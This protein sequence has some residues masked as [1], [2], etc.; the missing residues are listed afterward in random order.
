MRFTRL[1]ILRYGALTDRALA[2]R[3]DAQLH[4]IYGPNE[5]GKS[6]ALSAISD[7]LFGFPTAAEYSFLHDATALRVGAEIETRDGSKLGFR[8]RRG[9][10]NTL[11]A[12]SEAEEALPED[13][14]APFL[15]TLNRDVFQ[16]AFGLDSASLR[17]GGQSMLKSGGEIGSLLFSAASGLTGLSDLRKSFDAEAD[18]I[19]APRRSKDR[20]FY[21]VLDSHDEARKAERDNELKSGD[22]KKLLAEQAELEAELDTV[23]TERE[24]TK[25]TLERLR[26]LMRLEPVLREID[27]EQNQLAQYQALASL[28]PGFEDALA[29]ALDEARRNDDAHRAAET[30]VTRLRD[31]IA[32]LHVDDALIAAAGSILARHADKGVYLK[33]REDI[34]RV[35]GEVEDF[36]TRLVQL[37]RRLGLVR[38]DDLERHQP[39]DADLVRL[40]TLLDEGSE[41]DRSLKQL[42]LRLE[43]EREALRRL[44]EANPDSRLIDPKPWAEQLTALRPEL[45]D[46]AGIENLQVRATR[47][48]SDLAAAVARLDPPVKDIDALLASPLPDLAALSSHRKLID[49]ARAVHARINQTL[50]TVKAEAKTV[51]DQVAALEGQGR[52]VSRA[53]ILEAR[54]H[55]DAGLA[56]LGAKPSADQLGDVQKAVQ[57][58]DELA[59]AALTDAERV[60]RHAQLSLRQHEI[61]QQL[62]N[63]RAEARESDIALSDA[64]TEFEDL[65]RSV[66]ISPL[67]PERMLEWRRGVEALSHQVDALKDAN[68]A[69]QTARLKEDRLKPVLVG[70][71]D[72]IG[73]AATALPPAALARAL[74]RRLA[75]IAERWTESRSLEG[76]RHSAVD[77]L[78]RL[79]ERET[80]LRRE[81]DSWRASFSNAATMAGLQDEATVEMAAAALDVWR[82]VPDLLAERENR[83]RRVRGMQRDM[84]TFDEEIRSLCTKVAPD[85]ISVPADVAAGLLNDRAMDANAA[86]KHKAAM[87][88]DLERA[89][90]AFERYA[91]RE[92]TLQDELASLATS[93]SRDVADLEQVLE[94]L[95]QRS[96][97]NGQL[98]QCRSRFNEHADGDDEAAVRAA[99]VDFDKV[100]AGLEIEQLESADI[101][102]ID[103]IST[104][105]TAEAENARR[106]R[107]LESGIGA[108]RAVFQKHA[109]ETEAR[110]LARRW[111]VLKLAASLLS[112]S[113]ETYREQ[114]AD[115]VMQRAGK[116]FADLTGGR[117]AKLVQL[118]DEKD[119]LQLAVERNTGEQVPLSG[120]SEGTGDQLYLALRLAFL[121]DY[122][123][124][125]EPAPLILDDIFQTF[126]DERT[127]AGIRTLAAAGDKFQTVLFTHQLS[128]VETA[129]RELGDRLD[130]I[131]L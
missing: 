96:R 55:R 102:Q 126:D 73:L 30:E 59:D 118:Y 40:K 71:A 89:T 2:F 15:G 29:R 113:M 105:R 35:R 106:R 111:V 101:R 38:T 112:S 61:E 123:S 84:E 4:V 60:S 76:K 33:A 11:L 24:T 74:D 90:L 23:Q 3:P 117:F 63:A 7:L 88:A 82:S 121:E 79:E 86:A 44:D 75:E 21:Q 10:K 27:R 49:D 62:T 9:R 34:A 94:E 104:L 52:I 122:C 120:L 1:D 45:S 14:L 25:Q 119:E 91:T 77:A 18:T 128:L 31:E 72:A 109:A 95:R 69:L 130:L 85:L 92:K 65:F 39:A 50:T 12:A 115:P 16:R 54:Q 87:S 78:Q 98:Q 58:A 70:L 108:E 127:A 42:H 37:G 48:E 103:R 46:L 20:L 110:D 32:A 51:A 100:T 99:L 41:L 56:A 17:A 28:P 36:D 67:S 8:R 64:I 57:N 93:A 5:A 125:N 53:D 66:P 116:V 83:R 107:E 26:K 19:Y 13:A 43:E 124:R 97:L 81:V 47:A 80:V 6:S 131:K 129:Q 22:W 114:Q 68:D